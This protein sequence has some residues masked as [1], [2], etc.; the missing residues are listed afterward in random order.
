MSVKQS[1]IGWTD[2]SGGDLNF[3]SG[4]TPVSEGC[5]NCY[6]RA[7]YARWGKDFDTVR[8]YPAKL[9][10][11]T[12]ARWMYRDKSK[13][14]DGA[15]MCFVC[16]TGDLFHED[17]DV[18]FVFQALNMF[19]WRSDIMWQV[20]TKRAE[21]AREAV[22]H[23]MNLTGYDRL[24]PNVWLGVT[25]ENQA[26]ADERI[27]ILLDIPAAVRFVSVEPMLG[28]VDLDW[29]WFPDI[30][31]RPTYEYYRAAFP[32]MDDKPIVVNPGINWVICG[33]ES[34][35]K[36]RP[37]DVVWAEALYQQCKNAGVPF[38]GKQASGLRPGVPL[39][40]SDG[41]VHQWPEQS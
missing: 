5:Q 16:D 18:A 32:G 10:R 7:M 34:G 2:C 4:C 39:V 23:W 14:G 30:D 19:H 20:L 33:A 40:L 17:V 24:P 31:Y 21:R 15:R 12:T 11:L 8:A 35:P 41:I 29:G 36:R 6:A 13:R 28:P 27:P 38:F 25:T 22:R 37:F 26:R 1:A 3:V 9:M